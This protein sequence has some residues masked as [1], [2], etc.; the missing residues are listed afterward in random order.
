MQV[1]AVRL[2]GVSLLG[3]KQVETKGGKKK[4]AGVC[5]VKVRYVRVDM[6]INSRL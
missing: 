4:V 2:H 3:V 6:S 1:R 5:G